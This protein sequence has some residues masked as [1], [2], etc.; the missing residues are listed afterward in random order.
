MDQVGIEFAYGG[1]RLSAVSHERIPVVTALQ[2]FSVSSD[3]EVPDALKGFVARTGLKGAPTTYSV[4][5]DL[6][7]LH[8]TKLPRVSRAEL[9]EI[10]QFKLREHF[11]RPMEDMALGV[12]PFELV[13][14]DQIEA[15]VIAVPKEIVASRAQLIDRAGLE[16]VACE[17][18]AQSLIRIA[19]R[20]MAAVGSMFRQMSMTII[21][22]GAERTRFVVVQ[23]RRVQFIRTVKF[24]SNRLVSLVAS[25]LEVSQD[26]A[27]FYVDQRSTSIDTDLQLRLDFDGEL[28][29]V[30]VTPAMESLFKELRRLITYFRTLRSDRSY[31]GLMERLI[32]SGDLV[33]TRG[34]PETVGKTI[35]IRTQELNPLHGARISIDAPDLTPLASSPH[36]FTIALGLALSPYSN[37]LEVDAYG[38]TRIEAA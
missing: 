14:D 26:Q 1:L 37:P 21:D 24:G 23:N 17:I 3:L 22:L 31:R 33:S 27:Q 4:P 9:G 15:L 12:V 30:D 18:E 32:L 28:R 7:T 36:R 25:A 29:L 11:S 10:A 13:G 2:S 5:S 34:F 38:H 16:P 35:G 20:E 19:Q 8:W 6:A